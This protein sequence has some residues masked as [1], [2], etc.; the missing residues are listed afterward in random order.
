MARPWCD[1]HP[2]VYLFVP[3]KER[4]L[5]RNQK[6]ESTHEYVLLAYLLYLPERL[7]WCKKKTLLCNSSCLNPA[8]PKSL[9]QT[10]QRQHSWMLIQRLKHRM[11]FQKRRVCTP[12]IL[13]SLLIVIFRVQHSCTHLI[14]CTYITFNQQNNFLTTPSCVSVCL[15]KHA[16]RVCL[17]W[18]QWLLHT[19]CSRGPIALCMVRKLT[20]GCQFEWRRTTI[21]WI[22]VCLWSYI[23]IKISLIQHQ[24]YQHNKVVFSHHMA[25]CIICLEIRMSKKALP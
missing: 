25:W 18:S 3:Q 22:Y 8:P 20:V 21:W 23:T 9:T 17:I 1:T 24:L 13:Q 14:E 19:L 7:G 15:L 4:A 16:H 10:V 5:S 11:K 12:P 2:L 6:S